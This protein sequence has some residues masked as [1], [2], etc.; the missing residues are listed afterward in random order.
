[1]YNNTGKCKFWLDTWLLDAESTLYAIGDLVDMRDME[2]G[3]WFEGKIVRI[4][5]DPKATHTHD[6]P[7]KTNDSNMNGDGK[8]G[9]DKESDLENNPPEESSSPESKAKKKGIAR[10]FTKSPKSVKKKQADKENCSTENM[11]KNNDADLLYKVQLD[12]E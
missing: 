5:Q 6:T 8:P 2:Q 1:M 3:A 9:S 4:V 12:S 7:S 11:K 10:Y